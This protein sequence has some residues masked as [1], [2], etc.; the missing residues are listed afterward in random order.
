MRGAQRPVAERFHCRVGDA[1]SVGVDDEERDAV[2]LLL[3]SRRATRDNVEVARLEA[4]SEDLLAIEDEVITVLDGG[5][6]DGGS[7]GAGLGFGQ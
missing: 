3:T 6:A 5:Q 4:G 1:R 2:M 7:I